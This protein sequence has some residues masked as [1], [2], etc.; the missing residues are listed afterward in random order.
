[1]YQGILVIEGCGNPN[2]VQSIGEK[3]G[4]DNRKIGNVGQVVNQ[5]PALKSKHDK[6]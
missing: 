2:H 3:D 5:V 4:E 6:I 1:M